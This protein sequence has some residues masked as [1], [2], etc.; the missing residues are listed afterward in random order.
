MTKGTIV[1]VPFPFAD[2]ST[3]KVRPALCLTDVMAPHEQIVLVFISNNISGTRTSADILLEEDEAWFEQTKL[4][5]TSILR[6]NKLITVE[7]KIIR[8]KLDVVP[9]EV[10]VEVDMKLKE[11]FQ[12]R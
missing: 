3:V 4:R 9:E 10:L 7:K 8:V 12:L 5:T 11:V 2:F 6:L 1:L